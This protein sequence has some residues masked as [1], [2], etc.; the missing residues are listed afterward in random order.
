MPNYITP[1]LLPTFYDTNRVLDLLSDTSVDATVAD[2][3]STSS[4]PYL[5]CLQAIRDAG[6]EIDQHAQQGKRYTRD[7]L[8][9]IITEAVAAPADEVKQKRAAALRRLCA[10]LTFYFL[11][12][13]RGFTADRME[14]LAPRAEAAWKTLDELANGIRILDLD[15]NLAASI[16]KRVRI[17]SQKYL[18]SA[19]NHLF[20][21][22]YDGP[23]GSDYLCGGW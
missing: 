2:L 10:D 18:P 6:S 4:A 23:F 20:G 5:T 7:D 11:L 22:W 14:S 21:I 17:G 12:I 9:N 16:P 19:N 8:E 15:A 13:R 1:A 3:S